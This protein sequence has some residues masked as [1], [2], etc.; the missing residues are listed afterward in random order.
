[1]PNPELSMG[2]MNQ[3]SG[4]RHWQWLRRQ[5]LRRQWIEK[6]RLP[7]MA[8]EH[9]TCATISSS[10]SKKNLHAVRLKSTPPQSWWSLGQR[11]GSVF[12]VHSP[13][14]TLPLLFFKVVPGILELTNLQRVNKQY[15]ARCALGLT[16]TVQHRAQSNLMYQKFTIISKEMLQCLQ[17]S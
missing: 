15:A 1:M 10:L 6:K 9:T 3:N 8:V 17:Y 11:A 16:N 13:L 12:L 4:V 5:W 2:I 14:R 7:C